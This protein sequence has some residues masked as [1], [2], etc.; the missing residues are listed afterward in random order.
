[1]NLGKTKV[2]VSEAEG[3]VYGYSKFG[4]MCEMDS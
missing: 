1:M 4:A 3:E 2:V